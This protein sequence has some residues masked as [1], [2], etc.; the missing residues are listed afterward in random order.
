MSTQARCNY[1]YRAQVHRG[2]PPRAGDHFGLNSHG[3]VINDA[4]CGKPASGEGSSAVA[5]RRVLDGEPAGFGSFPWQAFIR[6]GKGKC[7]G[8]LISHRHV[9]TAGHC[10]KDKALNTVFVT[11]GEYN[12][13]RAEPLPSQTFRVVRIVVHPKFQF[14]P[15]ADR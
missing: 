14:S 10:V 9:V 7:G 6:I 5:S 2:R 12:L 13:R 8:V 11:M 3:P 1:L 4:Q 15:A